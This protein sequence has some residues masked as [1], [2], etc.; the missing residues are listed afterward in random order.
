MYYYVFSQ[1]AFDNFIPQRRLSALLDSRSIL[2]QLIVSHGRQHK[3]IYYHCF[4]QR[5]TGIETVYTYS[6]DIFLYK[7]IIFVVN[8]TIYLKKIIYTFFLSRSIEARYLTFPRD[9]NT[10]VS[11]LPFHHYLLKHYQHVYFGFS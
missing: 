7:I 3:S 11:R 6:A 10:N 2:Q 1:R 4:G 8:Q 9:H 5:K